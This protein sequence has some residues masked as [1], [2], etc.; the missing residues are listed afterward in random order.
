[1]HQRRANRTHKSAKSSGMYTLLMLIICEAE[2]IS[3]INLSK[4]R[5]GA[6][7]S[8]RPSRAPP[9][10]L[11]HVDTF[12]AQY[13]PH[14]CTFSSIGTLD[15]NTPHSWGIN[16]RASAGDSLGWDIFRCPSHVQSY[17]QRI[18]MSYNHPGDADIRT[19]TCT[20]IARSINPASGVI[21]R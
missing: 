4:D 20:P 6:T 16:A 12:K 1:M 19:Q 7:S 9:P 3:A 18:I 8:C 10:P 2:R 13:K 15:S 14:L 11:L 5:G 21:C 17:S